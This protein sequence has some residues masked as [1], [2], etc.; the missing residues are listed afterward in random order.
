MH[1]VISLRKINDFLIQSQH[2][3]DREQCLSDLRM[4]REALVEWQRPLQQVWDGTPRSHIEKQG[5]RG[6][7]RFWMNRVQFIWRVTQEA[8]MFFFINIP[9]LSARY[10]EIFVEFKKLKDN[11]IIVFESFGMKQL[12]SL[13]Q[14]A[15]QGLKWCFTAYTESFSHGVRESGSPKSS[16]SRRNWIQEDPILC[17]L[18]CF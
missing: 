15:N 14:W 7:R 4:A 6:F 8:M 13:S 12:F 2:G 11:L 17:L 1:A 10:N 16:H 5:K 18:Y 3:W 9:F